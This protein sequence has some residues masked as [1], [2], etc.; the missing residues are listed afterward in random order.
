MVVF[1]KIKLVAGNNISLL[2]RTFL[3]FCGGHR[4]NLGVELGA[5]NCSLLFIYGALWNPICKLR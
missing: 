1:L 3:L 5:W 4:R 2:S